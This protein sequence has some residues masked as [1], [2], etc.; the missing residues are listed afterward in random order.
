ML[1]ENMTWIPGGEFQMG[2]SNFYPEERPVNKTTVDS[3]WIDKTPVTKREFARFVEATDYKTVAE[4]T[5]DPEEYSSI[6]LE[7]FEPG[8][9]VFKPTKGPVNLNNPSHWWEFVRGANWRAPLG[10]TE[11]IA[12][13]HPVVQ[14][15]FEDVAAYAEWRGKSI[16]TE[17]EWEYAAKGGNEGAT[18]PWGNDLYPNGKA[19]A[20]TWDGEFPWLNTELDGY[21]GTSPV[22]T[23]PENGF[24]LLDMIGNVW[25]WTQDWWMSVHPETSSSPCCSSSSLRTN[26]RGGDLEASFDPQI[27][28]IK[29]PRKVLKGGSHLCAANYCLRYRPAARIPQMID[30]SSSHIG[31]RCVVRSRR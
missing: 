13:D 11:E 7:N 4:R 2:S 25:E 19:M 5:L 28:E 20:N 31:F 23:Y 27:P 3:F 12:T 30:T 29:I 16:P 14:V 9:L 10:K 22:D 21:A 26:P 15:A 1:T 8:S 24:G 18:F 6:D 17:A